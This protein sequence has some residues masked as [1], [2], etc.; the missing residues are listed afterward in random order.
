MAEVAGSQT[1]VQNQIDT[2]NSNLE[3]IGASVALGSHQG[4]GTFSLSQSIRNFRFIYIQIGYYASGYPQYGQA[5]IPVSRIAINSSET[6]AIRVV[7]HDS[8]AGSAQILFTSETAGNVL[9]ISTSTWY[10]AIYGIK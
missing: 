7:M 2:L 3:N 10:T 1:S 5:L 9:A 6:Y 8:S 4:T